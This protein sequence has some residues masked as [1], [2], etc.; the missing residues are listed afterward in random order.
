MQLARLGEDEWGTWLWA[1]RGTRSRYAGR[2]PTVLPVDFLM[3]IPR[4]AWWRATWM[5]ASHIDLYVDIGCPVEWVTPNRLRVVDLDLDVIRFTDGRCLIDDEDE[6][7]EHTVSLQYPPEVVATA[8][9]SADEVLVAVRDRVPP[10]GDP[11]ARWLRC[12]LGACCAKGTFVARSV[13][14]CRCD[15]RDRRMSTV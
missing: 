10:F 3:L 8:R 2:E 9:R 7:A 5:F 14:M 12:R 6:F 11:P 1:P 15:G 13:R 4:D